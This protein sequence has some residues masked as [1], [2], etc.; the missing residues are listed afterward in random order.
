M[1]MHAAW[2][3]PES[4]AAMEESM[5]VNIVGPADDSGLWGAA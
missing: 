5:V 2:T 1:Y 3:D 4:R